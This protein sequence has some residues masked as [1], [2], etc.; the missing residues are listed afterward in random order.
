[1]SLSGTSPRSYT[2][3]T[4]ANTTTTTTTTTTTPAT[5]A[6]TTGTQPVTTS[7]A[8]TSTT[9]TPTAA[10]TATAAAHAAPSLTGTTTTTSTTTTA[11]R[12]SP[13]KDDSP[14]S[15][16]KKTIPPR[17]PRAM[18]MPVP[19]LRLRSTSS[20]VEFFAA[21]G[22]RPPLS[23]SH[24]VPDM[25][26]ALTK[27]DI[28]TTL[29]LTKVE[30][31]APEQT[32]VRA[33]SEPG[34]QIVRKSIP[35]SQLKKMEQEH[36]THKLADLLVKD[37]VEDSLSAGQL[38]TL[39]RVDSAFYTDR[40]P[41][42]FKP[43]GV[44]M[45]TPT[46]SSS[47]LLQR[48][49][50]ADFRDN[51]GW[52]GARSLYANFMR[53][54][55]MKAT[56]TT[57]MRTS[58]TD[59][60]TRQAE[61]E[62]MQGA[63]E[64]IV[65]TLLGY[66]PTVDS[67]PLPGKLLSLLIA[68]DQRLHAKLLASDRKTAFSTEQIRAGRLAV[69][70]NLLVTR[71]LQ[72]MLL[73]LAAK[74]PSQAE[75]LFQAM[76]MKGLVAGAEQLSDALFNKSFA[77]SSLTLQQQATEKLTREKIDARIRQLQTKPSTRHVRTRSADT[78]PISPRTLRTIEEAR[79]LRKVQKAGEMAKELE[80]QD[81]SALDDARREIDENLAISKAATELQQLDV[82]D[83]QDL[84]R[85]MLGERGD[86]D[87]PPV[88]PISPRRAQPL[89]DSDDT[90]PVAIGSVAVMPAPRGVTT[91]TANTFTTTTT[92][93]ATTTATMAAAPADAM[94]HAAIAASD[95]AAGATKKAS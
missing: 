55:P 14:T 48:Y 83:L 3:P 1:M 93:T 63:A 20:S 36:R 92:S 53:R 4:T 80:S 33:F 79:N 57:S 42:E 22:K 87:M 38:N 78:T 65:R 89:E 71:L 8:A 25:N 26:Q 85:M 72:P 95:K 18:P 49:F 69:L 15:R 37:L 19:A 88:T 77:A 30:D 46:I 62:R 76:L 73:S 24:P 82:D 54:E 52:E 28:S 86:G 5:T 90:P 64:V 43:L 81:W 51:V 12:S 41:Q 9:A 60:D 75:M 21:P 27:T 66:P 13:P 70:S 39:G 59:A 74:I 10:T 50:A 2:I 94:T 61:M 40:L 45:D 34:L 47:K 16:L 11:T 7:T 56:P 44:G 58:E 91:T 23:H 68:C 31:A 35:L 17:S 32:S 67:S 29:T 84:V 6:T